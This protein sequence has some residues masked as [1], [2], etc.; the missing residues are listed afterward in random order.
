MLYLWGQVKEIIVYIY[1]HLS[2]K[3]SMFQVSFSINQLSLGNY[4]SI[5]S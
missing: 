1:I 3:Y 4:C 2:K 5:H